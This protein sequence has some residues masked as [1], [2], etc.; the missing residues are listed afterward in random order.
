MHPQVG[1]LSV[2]FEVLAPLQDPDQRLV[3]YRAADPASQI[4]LEQ[5][6]APALLAAP[7]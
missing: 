5:L 3:I 2:H 6:T 4:A 7:A 1:P